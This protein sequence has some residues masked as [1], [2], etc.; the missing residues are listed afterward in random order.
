[1]P[2]GE[3]Q[4]RKLPKRIISIGLRCQK[5]PLVRNDHQPLC[6]EKARE[7]QHLRREIEVSF[8][9]HLQLILKPHSPFVWHFAGTECE[10]VVADQ[11]QNT[12]VGRG[13]DYS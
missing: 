9:D 12:M 4:I 10:E 5:W 1:M 8:L 7:P 2:N 13:I 6:A 3:I 11:R